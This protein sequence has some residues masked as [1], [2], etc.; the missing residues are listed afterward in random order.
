MLSLLSS[1]LSEL[2][3]T[4]L[5][6]ASS[7]VRVSLRAMIEVLSS[8]RMTGETSTLTSWPMMWASRDRKSTRLNSSH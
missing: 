8:W 4:A 6:E 7:L 5:M 3:S 2:A 1:L